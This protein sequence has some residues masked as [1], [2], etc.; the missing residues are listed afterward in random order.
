MRP[1]CWEVL[2][3]QQT[4]RTGITPGSADDLMVAQGLE[5]FEEEN[6]IPRESSKGRVSRDSLSIS[7]FYGVYFSQMS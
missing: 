5:Q 3:Q 2:R 1:W 7:L 4:H 6:R